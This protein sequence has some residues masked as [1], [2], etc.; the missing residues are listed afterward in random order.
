VPGAS[1]QRDLDR[2]LVYYNLDRSHQG[3]R[4]VSFPVK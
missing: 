4:L 1:I 3:Y 2:F